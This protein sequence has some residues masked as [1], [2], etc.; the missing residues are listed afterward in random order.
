MQDQNNR[1]WAEDY[2]EYQEQMGTLRTGA[3]AGDMVGVTIG[4]AIQ[5]G[6][7]VAA[8]VVMFSVGKCVV[9]G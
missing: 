5:I 2:A 7:V 3:S 6:L 9:G 1:D 8:C 4:L